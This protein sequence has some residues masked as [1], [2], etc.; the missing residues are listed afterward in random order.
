MASEKCLE[1]AS[2]LSNV[3]PLQLSYQETEKVHPDEVNKT[4]NEKSK[5]KR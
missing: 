5:D 3:L 4:R 2:D 1:F